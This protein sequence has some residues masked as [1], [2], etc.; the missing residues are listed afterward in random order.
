MTGVLRI[1]MTSLIIFLHN[2]P[3]HPHVYPSD[4][5]TTHIYLITHNTARK[6]SVLA[7]NPHKS[8]NPVLVSLEGTTTRVLVSLDAD[9]V[10]EI[11]KTKKDKNKKGKTQRQ[12][13]R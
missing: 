3:C 11:A 13:K 2:N 5:L 12:K 4:N 9:I 7:N 6:Q 8:N 1:I 10:S